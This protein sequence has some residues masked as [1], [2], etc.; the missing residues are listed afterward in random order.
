[1]AESS[2]KQKT[3]KGLFWGGISSGMQQLLSASFGIYFARILSPDDYGLV[4]MLAIFLGIA[5]VIVYNGLSVA[6]TNKAD[7]NQEDYNAVFWATL[8]LGI[9]IYVLLFFGAPLIA[10]FYK[11]PE[12]TALSRVLFLVFPF[13]ALGVVSYTV[14][15]KKLMT[16]QQAMIDIIAMLISLSTGL[17]LALKGYAYW[18][19]VIQS[20]IQIALTTVLKFIIAPWK[21]TLT[22][23]FAPL[24]QMFSFSIK[25]F[26]TGIFTQI[27][28]NIFSVLLGKFY[29]ETQVGYYSQGQ[30]WTVM[31]S[32]FIGGMIMYVTQPVLVQVNEDPERQTNVLRKLIR[33]GAFLS[34]PLMLGLA[35]VGKEFILITIGEKW[36][37]AI[38]FLQLFCIWSAF[39]FLWTLYTNLIFTKGHSNLYMYGMLITG[40]LQLIA[41]ICLYPL[42]ILPMIAGYVFACFTGLIIWQYYVH[43]LTGLRL[44]DVLKDILPYLGVT[45]F[46]FGIAWLLTKNIRNLYWLFAGKIVIVGLLYLFIMKIS[47]SV[48]FKECM[49][50]M[51]K[52]KKT[53]IKE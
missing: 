11:A 16:K 7:A 33:F 1:M 12:L 17:F 18:A 42:G 39:G 30:K 34:F 3:A 47:N 26:F 5:G 21:P 28:T 19:L 45:L 23:N 35:F 6:L 9:S 10:E 48:I 2:L 20:L 36:L 15:F 53:G 32:Q 46:C 52:N 44:K 27:T 43:K 51:R 41:I 37:P 38:P 8:F 29:N 50:F 14:M 31:G 22:I 13:H 25:L 40:L 49:E 24:K 4:A